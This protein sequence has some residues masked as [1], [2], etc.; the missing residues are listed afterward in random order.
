MT[1]SEEK[2]LMDDPAAPREL[3]RGELENLCALNRYLG[4]YRCAAK[5]LRRLIRQHRLKEFS[6]L[7]VGAGSA[8][9]ASGIARWARSKGLWAKITALDLDP[10]AVE[11][12]A[13]RA[14]RREIAVVRADAAAPPFRPLSFDFV[15]ASQFLHHFSEEKIVELLGTWSK[16]ARRAMIVSDLLRHPL[17]YHGVRLLTR[18]FTRNVMTSTDA[19]LSVARAFTLEEWRALFCR[20]AIGRFQVDT[21]FPFRIVGR[22]EL[23]R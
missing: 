10:L 15:L 12:A 20:A 13:D 7:D 9:I 1:R 21:V 14:R 2:E 18:L 3:R 19:P 22:V 6:L 16:L 8:D 5:E 23:L 4:G 17:A 11:I